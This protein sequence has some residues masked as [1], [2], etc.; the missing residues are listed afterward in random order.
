MSLHQV[1]S[2]IK[3][4]DIKLF[5]AK[6]NLQVIH[7]FK[8]VNNRNLTVKFDDLHELSFSIPYKVDINHQLV[9]NP[10]IALVRERFVIKVVYD[11]IEEHF[12]I[13]KLTKSSDS[14]ANELMV[15]CFHLPYEL[16]YKRYK[17]Y[18]STS[19]NCLQVTNDCLDG[20]PWKVGYID[21]IFN[22]KYRQFDL[23]SG[24]RLDFL[25]EIGKSFVAIKT[26]DTAKRLVN[27][28]QESTLSK[29]KGL[30]IKEGQ[31]ID[32]ISDEIDLDQLVTRL[33][34]YGSEDLTINEVSPNGQSYV[35]DFSYFLYPFTMDTE[36]NVTQHSNYMSDDLCKAII[37]HA[38]LIEENQTTLSSYFNQI[39]TIQQ[40]IT[41]INNKISDAKSALTQANDNLK[42]ALANGTGTKLI[43]EQ[44]NK[45]TNDIAVQNKA[46]K[47]KNSEIDVIKLKINDLNNILVLENYLKDI[48]KES[49]IEELQYYIQEDEYIDENIIDAT[50][51][52]NQGLSEMSKRNSPPVNISI[53]LIDFLACIEESYNWDKL[54]VGDLVNIIHPSM[55]IKIQAKIAQV[56][57]DFE[58]ESI[59]LGITNG[60]RILSDIEKVIRNS[61]HNTKTS[62]DYQNRKIN[63]EKTSYNFNNRNDRISEIPADPS[64]GNIGAD[65]VHVKNDDGSVTL[66]VNWNFPTDSSKNEYNID[67]FNIYLYATKDKETVTLG[68]M[69]GNESILNVDST[70]RKYTIPSVP[71]NSYFYIGVQSYRHVDNDIS[72]EGILLSEIIIPKFT[73]SYPYKPEEHAEFKGKLNGVT[74]TSSDSE[75][76]T[77]E[78]DDI[79]YDTINNQTKIYTSDGWSITDAGA[80]SDGTDRFTVEDIKTISDNA[81]NL[82]QKTNWV[83]V[84]EYG[85]KGD[86]ITDDTIAVQSAVDFAYTMLGGGRVVFPS[87]LFKLDTIDLKNGVI[88]EGQGPSTILIPLTTG[89]IIFKAEGSYE[90][91]LTL[92]ADASNHVSTIL[93][94]SGHGYAVNDILMIMSQRD[95]LSDDAGIIPWYPSV[96]Y[97]VGWLSSNNGNYYKVTNVSSP[98]ANGFGTNGN[99]APTHTS[100]DFIDGQITWTYMGTLLEGHKG[101][102]RLGYA[103]PNAQGLYFGEFIKAKSVSVNSVSLESGLIYPSYRID[104][105]QEHA[106][107]ARNASTVKKFLPVKNVTIRNFHVASRSTKVIVLKNTYNCLVDNITFN[108]DGDGTVVSIENSLN[109]R[110]HQCK[111]YYTLA[112]SPAQI[113]TRNAFKTVSSQNCGFISCYA[114][115]GSQSFDT[116]YN[117]G[118]VPST[119]CYVIDCE[120]RGSMTNSMTTH[121]GSYAQQVIGNRFLNC[122]GAGI[123]IRSRSSVISNNIVQGDKTGAYGIM[124]YEGWARDCIVSSNSIS[125]FSQG[126]AVYDGSD[127]GETFTWVGGTFSNNKIT[128]VN[129][130]MYLLKSGNNKYVGESGVEFNG[131][132]VSQFYGSYAKPV[133]IESYYSGVTVRNNMFYGSSVPNGGVY[134]E[135]NTDRITVSENKFEGIA[136]RVI[137]STNPTDSV[138]FPSLSV[139]WNIGENEYINCTST[140]IYLDTNVYAPRYIRTGNVLNLPTA[141]EAYRG[142]MIRVEGGTG[143]SDKT[144]MC[145]KSASDTY[146]WVQIVTG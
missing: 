111:V 96:S 132:S 100:G 145:M 16:S 112:N 92:T 55:G 42:I 11:Q 48:S 98:D 140:L 29:Y 110:A 124:L 133:Y 17:S 104:K 70:A 85:A 19:Y 125:G 8:D 4:Q 103:T 46:V 89:S 27:F 138:Q 37:A 82:S 22:V 88:V 101:D 63:W 32:G 45:L 34:V 61:Y 26:Y 36:G 91:E 14:D 99:I 56:D 21:P 68:S 23:S 116:T 119:H 6:P 59:S 20:T 142:Q 58:N 77:P 134:G 105:T 126:V 102:W 53:N 2:N 74:H 90:T 28:Y 44:I 65:I 41:E 60:T 109:S 108:M 121:G 128:N 30:N 79:W 62:K 66:T 129:I 15:N 135:S 114:E 33:F 72:P 31:Y 67:G 43:K 64:F 127:I 40:A 106:P 97:K 120:T 93:V 94:P 52:Y 95:C 39:S 5:L 1:M 136:G 78:V 9:D 118:T 49:L 50:D 107:L 123:S 47:V 80:I 122:N 12:V 137:W 81:D 141:S 84:R 146:S 113:Y 144:Y 71:A 3:K 131:N 117:T 7:K 115:N 13:N 73:S 76:S 24:K 130:G 69:G 25:N 87:G 54:N 10:A 57:Y 75:P 143:V 83:D 18:S 35:E 139:T 51:L 38:K 86:G